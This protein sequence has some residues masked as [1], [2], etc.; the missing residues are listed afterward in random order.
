[1]CVRERQTDRQRDRDR[2]TNGVCVL[3]LAFISA[4]YFCFFI[5]F[6]LFLLFC[7]SPLLS[8]MGAPPPPPPPHNFPALVSRWSFTRVVPHALPNFQCP[9]IPKVNSALFERF[10]R[11]SAAFLSGIKSTNKRI[12]TRK[13]TRRQQEIQ[14]RVR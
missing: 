4:S 14:D 9:V 1:M 11:V 12:S 8:F 2:Q 6:R 7:L 13:A 5:I 10:M 3:R